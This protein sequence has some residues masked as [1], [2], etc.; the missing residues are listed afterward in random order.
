MEAV[1]YLGGAFAIAGVMTFLA[2]LRRQVHTFKV[3]GGLVVLGIAMAAGAYYVSTRPAAAAAHPA[4]PVTS[5]STALA[6][7]SPSLAIPTTVA[8]F[9]ALGPTRGKAVMQ[10][11]L[12]RYNSVLDE[13][14][15]N[16]D[17]SLLPEVTTGPELQVQQQQLAQ[18][19][20]EGRPTGGS[21]SYTITG[22]G[23]APALGSVTVNIQGSESSWYLDPTTL[24]QV[25]QATVNN[26]PASYTFVPEDGTWKVKVVV[27]G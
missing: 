14:Y 23:T 21:D 3:G 9:Q 17:P 25:G 13:A 8:A 24:Q 1:G 7:A 26:Q 27:L 4:S 18:L 2:Q 22:I 15:R 5:A 11:E 12:D 16:L 19:K 6:Q 10:E 20:A